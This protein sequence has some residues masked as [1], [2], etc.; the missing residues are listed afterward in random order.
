MHILYSHEITS[1]TSLPNVKA[2]LPKK[3][4]KFHRSPKFC[5]SVKILFSDRHGL[6]WRGL[7]GDL[8]VYMILRII[9]ASVNQVASFS[10]SESL[11]LSATPNFALF[12]L[13][14]LEVVLCKNEA[15]RK[16]FIHYIKKESLKYMQ[17]QCDDINSKSYREKNSIGVKDQENIPN[18][19]RI[20]TTNDVYIKAI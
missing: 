16:L 8:C 20:K 19:W 17:N 9:R 7:G 10:H 12:Y 5:E 13:W 3:N 6:G 18:S 2:N 1:Q 14:D 11:M 4:R 15:I